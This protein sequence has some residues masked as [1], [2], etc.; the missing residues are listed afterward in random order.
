MTVVLSSSESVNQNII[1]KEP[2]LILVEGADDQALSALMIRHEGLENFRVHNMTG[3]T[4]W[5]RRIGVIAKQPDF[6]QNV[7]SLG[8]LRDADDDPGAAWDSCIG[9]LKFCSLPTPREALELAAGTPNT[10]IMVVPSRTRRGAV[11]ELCMDSFPEPRLACV[12]QYFG[13]LGENGVAP[14]HAK[15]RIQVYLA[16]LRDNPRDLVV[17]CKKGLLDMG[18]P[19]FDELRGF[20]R[21]LAVA[22]P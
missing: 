10:A 2:H 4:S 5:N 11:E 17:A 22:Q 14:T 19:A 15:G 9:A 7:T 12:D 3:K 8:L 18:H 20:I 21:A 6:Q 13:C 16:G 1:F